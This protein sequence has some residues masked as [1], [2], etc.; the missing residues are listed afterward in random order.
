[1]LLNDKGVKSKRTCMS[2]MTPKES[3]TITLSL[4][5]FN[6]P[7]LSSIPFHSIGRL[8]MF[9]LPS[10]VKVP[11]TPTSKQQQ[12]ARQSTKHPS[13]S[14]HREQ[15]A[16]MAKLASSS[17]FALHFIRRLLCAHSAGNDSAGEGATGGPAQEPE[18]RSPCIVARLMGLDAM[19]AEAPHDQP[20]ALRR[21]R[22]ASYAEGWPPPCSGGDAPRPRA[23][24][25]S[26]SLREKPAYLR[27]ENEEFLLLSFSP[28]ERSTKEGVSLLLADAG[29]RR[30]ERRRDRA[31][32]Q[33]RGHRRKLQFGDQ[34]AE[35]SLGRRRAAECDTLNSS[36]VSV[37]EAR[38]GYEASSTTTTTWSSLEE[39][40]QA[41]PCSATSGSCCVASSVV[42]LLHSALLCSRLQRRSS[43]HTRAAE[44]KEEAATEFRPVRQPVSCRKHLP[45]LKMFRQGEDEQ[46]SGEQG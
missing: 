28:E 21:S 33:G 46:K 24:R 37:L 1:M 22:S 41:E 43:V 20:Q 34:E 5:F 25:T 29:T 39:V 10:L 40:E 31:K 8:V 4:A 9:F 36:P 18:A 14:T 27:Q 16:R 17:S 2:S 30:G 44:L 23:I 38:D 15:H 3:F 45:C 12:H 26:A 42:W 32:E 35:S 6:K 19:P 7:R 11:S 13:R